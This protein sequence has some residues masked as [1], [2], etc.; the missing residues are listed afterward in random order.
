[1]LPWSESIFSSNGISDMKSY[2]I[3]V[4][5][6][7]IVASWQH[8]NFDLYPQIIRH[9]IKSQL[10]G[11]HK[12]EH[13][14]PRLVTYVQTFETK[15]GK[16][17]SLLPLLW[18]ETKVTHVILASVHLYDTPGVIRLNDH[19]FDSV[20]YDRTWQE[21]KALQNHGV[22]VMAML[23]GAAGGTYKHFNRS[24]E[25]VGTHQ[26]QNIRRSPRL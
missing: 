17:V 10:G 13:P 4:L 21:V 3:L 24:E 23:G 22:K 19:P 14:T 7:Q 11:Y 18:H 15:E 6:L 1:V 20:E 16:H 26:L 5:L 9:V 8:S 12:P 2:W 25:E